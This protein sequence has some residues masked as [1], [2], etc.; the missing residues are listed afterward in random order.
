[1]AYFLL[2]SPKPVASK[3]AANSALSCMSADCTTLNSESLRKSKAV[4]DRKERRAVWNSKQKSRS[5]QCV[6][7]GRK[8]HV[9]DFKWTE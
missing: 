4:S 6:W 5:I 2:F 7:S 1:M 9:G 8:G 3:I